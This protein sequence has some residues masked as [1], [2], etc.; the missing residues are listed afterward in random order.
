MKVV[1][2]RDVKDTGRAHEVVE[3]SD[4]HALNFLIPKKFAVAATK[5]AVAAAES[6]LKAGAADR[7]NRAKAVAD[8]LAALAAEKLTITKKANDQG[9]LYEALTAAEIS[10]AAGI[11]EDAIELDRPIKEVGEHNVPVSFGSDS[12]EFTLEVVAE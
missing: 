1:L 2:T 12:G 4:G 10:A 8:R 5:G 11:P 3:V 6:R 9:H 7:E